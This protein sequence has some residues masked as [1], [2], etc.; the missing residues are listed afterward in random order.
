[1]SYGFGVNLPVNYEEALQLVKAALKEQGFGVLTEIDVK[2]T[3]FVKLGVEINPYMIYGACNPQ[4]AYRAIQA[5]PEIGL[6]LPCN[7]TIRSDGNGSRIDVADPNAM[8]GVAG[9]EALTAI[10]AEAR[11]KLQAAIAHLSAAPTA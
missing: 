5:E 11:T 3:M 1:M 7:V 10:A 9:N 6:L 2:S 4:L 8:L